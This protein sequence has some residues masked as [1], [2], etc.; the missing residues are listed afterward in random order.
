MSILQL[1]A[2][3]GKR[4]VFV[5]KF[6]NSGPIGVPLMLQAFNIPLY[7]IIIKLLILIKRA[8]WIDEQNDK[9]HCSHMNLKSLNR[10]E[11]PV[12]CGY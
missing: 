12:I 9:K 11:I 8:R 1:K 7:R 4:G 3:E 6:F 5:E 10:D 2:P